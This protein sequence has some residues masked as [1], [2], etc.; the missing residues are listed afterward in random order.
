MRAGAPELDMPPP[1]CPLCEEKLFWDGGWNCDN[2]EA[3]WTDGG[4]FQS[5]YEYD[6]E[7]CDYWL[8]YATD[9]LNP[10]RCILAKDHENTHASRYGLGW[11]IHD[12]KERD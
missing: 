3:S 6:A 9:P 5:W 7:Q 2:C 10:D 4:E 12:W 1:N 11:N 8:H